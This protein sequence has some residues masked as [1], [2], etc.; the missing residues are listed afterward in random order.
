M[1]KPE[2]IGDNWL[3]TPHPLRPEDLFGRVVLF[4]FWTYSCV[5]C[6]RT[7]PYLQKIWERY[8]SFNF[9]II[10][11]HAPEF[12]FEKD[13]ENVS[14]AITQLGVHWPVVLDNEHINWNN[15]ANHYWP[16]EYLADQNGYIV[17]EHFGEGGYAEI[18]KKIQELL[19]IDFGNRELPPIAKEE[20]GSGFCI[21]STPELYLG[22]SRGRVVN[23]G[24][25]HENHLGHYALPDIIP[26]DSSALLGDFDAKPEYIES[27]GDGGAI[28]LN[29]NATEV[30]LVM[31]PI[32]R[33][34]A[35]HLELDGIE[36][37]EQMYGSDVDMGD[38]IISE[39]RM[40]SLLKSDIPIKGILKIGIQKSN[41][42]AY[43]FTFSGCV[44]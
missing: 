18:E 33:L 7:I 34:A 17:H 22:Y 31:S 20:S 15:F 27:F 40:Y 25:Y 12:E 4:D 11:I 5:N 37:P 6:L 32:D 43:A 1:R 41:I 28:F 16:A 30:N 23:A 2:I 8:K 44:G 14:T 39:S 21:V 9:Y 29:F 26:P 24:G 38:A 19:K 10:G 13:P 42:R 36:I 35:V 3:N